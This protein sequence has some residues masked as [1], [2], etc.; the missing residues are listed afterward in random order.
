M[1]RKIHLNFQCNSGRIPADW[2]ISILVVGGNV[3]L[4]EYKIQTSV[5]TLPGVQMIAMLVHEHRAL[6]NN[7][8]RD[9]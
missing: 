2:M 3:I 4:Y 1:E 6:I 7:L 5:K 8:A 9:I